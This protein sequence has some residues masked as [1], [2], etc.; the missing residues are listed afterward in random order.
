MLRI[1]FLGRTVSLLCIM[2]AGLDQTFA[3][4]LR[5]P[6]LFLHTRPK[7]GYVQVQLLD[8]AALE[9]LGIPL[10]CI[11]FRRHKLVDA[12]RRSPGSR[13]SRNLLQVAASMMSAALAQR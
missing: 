7:T 11:G 10:I 12:D 4:S 3:D 1:V 5:R 6:R 13:M 2:E 8:K 9:P